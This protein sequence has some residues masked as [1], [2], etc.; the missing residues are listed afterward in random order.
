MEHIDQDM[1][2]ELMGYDAAMDM[3]GEIASIKLLKHACHTMSIFLT[4]LLSLSFLALIAPFSFVQLEFSK[5]WEFAFYF[6][7]FSCF[8]S[9]HGMFIYGINRTMMRQEEVQQRESELDKKIAKYR[10]GAA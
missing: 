1:I 7:H 3:S 2:Y 6:I 8:S 5:P 9:A 4:V 10:A